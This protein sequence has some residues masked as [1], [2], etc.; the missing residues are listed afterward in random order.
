MKNLTHSYKTVD[1]LALFA[2]TWIPETE[3]RRVIALVH[4]LGEHS[5]RFAHVAEFFGRSGYAMTGYDLRGHGKSEGA[6]GHTPSWDRLLDDVDLHI[7]WTR[8]RFPGLPVLLYGHSLGGLQVLSRLLTRQGAAH[9]A[10]ETEVACIIATSPLLATA[11]PIPAFKLLMAK[12][13]GRLAPGV[14]MDNGLDVSD[15]AR[16]PEV[17]AKAKAD[18]LYHRKVTTGMGL[19][20]MQAGERVRAYKGPV[21]RPLLLMQGTADAI[22]SPGATI[23]LAQ[24]LTGDVTLKTWDGMFHE[25]H[26]EPQKETILSFARDWMESRAAGKA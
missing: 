18:P 22:V 25:L 17:A 6:R 13:L 10:S 14:A 19:A 11:E 2:Q 23:E 16:D 3:P 8:R 9:G 24:G 7:A 21:G 15:L 4:G 5:S 20:F 1:G 12:L 26:N